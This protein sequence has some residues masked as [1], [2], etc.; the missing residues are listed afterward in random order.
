MVHCNAPNEGTYC[1]W[2]IIQI[3]NQVALQSD[4][5]KYLAP[6]KITQGSTSFFNTKIDADDAA[7]AVTR[8]DI[9]V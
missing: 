9:V 7:K 6:G 2:T 3:G 4:T 8:W 5:G 1:Q